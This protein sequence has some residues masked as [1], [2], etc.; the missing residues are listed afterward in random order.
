MREALWHEGQW[1]KSCCNLQTLLPA[2]LAPI[3]AS[4]ITKKPALHGARRRRRNHNGEASSPGCTGG[5]GKGLDAVDDFDGVQLLLFLA[6]L[7][8]S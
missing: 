8:A 7:M 4:T 1:S 6:A 3:K 2:P 5:I